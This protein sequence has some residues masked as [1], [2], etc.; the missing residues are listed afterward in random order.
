MKTLCVVPN[1]IAFTNNRGGFRNCCSA[2]PQIHSHEDNFAQWWSSSAMNQFR[3]QLTQE[4]LPPD[5][6]GCAI[7]EKVQGSSFRTS[8]SQ[9]ITDASWPSGWNV[10][11]G[12]T[13]N[14]GCWTCN[15]NNSSVIEQH[16]RRIKILPDQFI[17]PSKQFDQAW[18]DIQASIMKS[19]QHHDTVTLTLLGGEP[20][21]NS[22]LLE[23]LN[24]LTAQG[25]APRTR[26]EFHTNVTT[27]GS[28]PT[29][30]WQYVCVFLSIDAI[31]KKAEWLRY[32]SSWAKIEHNI[33]LLKQQ[34]NYTEVHCTLS[35]LNLKDLPEL[36][37]FCKQQDLPLRIHA[38]QTPAFM[39][40]KYW[41]GPKQSLCSKDALDQAGFSD[42]YDLLGSE[43]VSGNSSKLKE[44]IQ[45]FDSI[46][47]PLQD[48]DPQLAALIL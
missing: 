34:A 8:V 13:C 24:S 40:I 27:S 46:R 23:F 37:Q 47:K 18:P 5:C 41:D 22:Q 12:N 6:Q 36:K 14:L 11:F 21:Y 30:N 19:Y 31:G 20:L 7:Q 48:F 4:K 16:K 10:I 35:I 17:S 26:L 25:L 2:S 45:Q 32:G 28:L 29:G 42:Y 33:P 3:Q 15:E 43:P 38:M 39:A 1:T 9:T 44:Y